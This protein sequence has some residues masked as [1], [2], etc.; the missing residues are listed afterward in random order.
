MAPP[1]PYPLIAPHQRSRGPLCALSS[2]LGRAVLL[3]ERSWTFSG[4]NYAGMAITV[5]SD[6]FKKGMAITALSVK[7]VPWLQRQQMLK[8]WVGGG[9]GGLRNHHDF[10]ISAPGAR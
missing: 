5:L 6:D 4:L 1:R 9:R 2:P 3:N 7:G 8:P 10:P